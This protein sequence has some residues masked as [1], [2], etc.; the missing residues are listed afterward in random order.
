MLFALLALSG[1]AAQNA[2][3][4]SLLPRAIEQR[5]DEPE[6]VRPERVATADSAIDAKVAE[7]DKATT[8]SANDFPAAASRATTATKAAVGASVGSEPWLAAQSALADVDAIRAQDLTTLAEIDQL[9]IDRGT[10]GDPPYPALVA[11]RDRVE[12][13]LNTEI[14]VIDKLQAQLVQR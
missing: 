8:A 2:R 1:C 3:S 13:Q 10:A 7:F 14:S 4:P 11:M 12:A 6:P 9:Q 5:R